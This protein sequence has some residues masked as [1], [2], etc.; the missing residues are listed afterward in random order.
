MRDAAP[1]TY[2]S[3][4]VLAPSPSVQD[5]TPQVIG[6]MDKESVRRVVR[7]NLAQIRYCY[8]R[9]LQKNPALAGKIVLQMTIAPTGG[10]KEAVLASSSISDPEVGAC[11]V[12]RAKTWMF[13]A[14]EATAV[15]AKITI[16]M[17]AI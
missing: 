12:G 1:L 9:T 15:A 13:P 17:S 3:P 16:K 8:E 11:V 6:S 2:N 10:V 14:G 5:A 7:R 4:Q